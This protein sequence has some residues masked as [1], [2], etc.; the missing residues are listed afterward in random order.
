MWNLRSQ[1]NEQRNKKER[2]ANHETGSFN[3][4]EQSDGDQSEKG[5][6]GMGY[7]SDG[8]QRMHL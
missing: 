8:D 1:T 3:S 4:R 5:C 7:I 6:G 2:K